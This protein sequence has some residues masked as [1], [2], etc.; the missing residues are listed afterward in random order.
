MRQERLKAA[1]EAQ[2][3]HHDPRRSGAAAADLVDRDFSAE[4]PNRLWVVGL[5]VVM[6]W[7][8]VVYG[9][10]VIDVFSRRIVG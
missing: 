1:G 6:T 8:G 9:A 10:F 4:A 7:S 5:H 3:P 2:A